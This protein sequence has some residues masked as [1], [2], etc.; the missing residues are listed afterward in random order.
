M[1]YEH[2]PARASYAPYSDGLAKSREGPTSMRFLVG[3]SSF[4]QLA[5]SDLIDRVRVYESSMG[6]VPDSYL[7]S[8]ISFIV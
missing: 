2:P 6:F 5:F 4:P 1:R 8:L 3:V 7:D